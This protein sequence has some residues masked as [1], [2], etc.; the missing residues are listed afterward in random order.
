MTGKKTFLRL[1]S[2]RPVLRRPPF[3]LSLAR[4]ERKGKDKK[5]SG[6]AKERRGI[7]RCGHER[8]VR[9]CRAS[10]RMARKEGAGRRGE[11]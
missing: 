1:T 7:R 5:R 9:G 3:F 4:Q 6:K 10:E 11:D 2:L 8:L